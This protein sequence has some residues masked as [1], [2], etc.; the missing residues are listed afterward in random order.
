[1]R[2]VSEAGVPRGASVTI[3]TIGFVV[4]IGITTRGVL[5][6]TSPPS[7]SPDAARLPLYA[8]LSRVAGEF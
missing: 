4:G 2:L 5:L 6:R 7:G 8:A 1:M 3:S